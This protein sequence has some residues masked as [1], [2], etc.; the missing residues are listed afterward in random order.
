MPCYSKSSKFPSVINA[1]TID[2]TI[3]DVY[4]TSVETT[5][6]R[7]KYIFYYQVLEYCSYYYLSE[8]NKRNLERILKM[9]DVSFNVDMYSKRI[10]DEFKD[11]ISQRDD[12]AK[13]RQ[14]ISDFCSFDDIKN[15][16]EQNAV[17]F[18]KDA[19]FDGG[20]EVKALAGEV[21]VLL[22]PSNGNNVINTIVQNIED[23]RNV[24][25]HLRESRENKVI[26]PSSENDNKLRPY[27]YLLRRIAEKV[28]IQFE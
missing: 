2:P 9:P 1:R 10:I 23:I 26:L 11:Q 25:V 14:I 22:N 18:C 24:L 5:N 21:N 3:L 28:A 4:L 7:L 20:F 13:I 19:V 15:E 16:L 17:Y 27:M 6:N 8:K 12:F